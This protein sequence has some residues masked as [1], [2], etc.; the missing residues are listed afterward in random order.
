MWIYEE[1]LQKFFQITYICTKNFING[2]MR[3]VCKNF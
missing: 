1:S 3:K 2:Y